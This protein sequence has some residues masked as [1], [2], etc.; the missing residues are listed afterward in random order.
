MSTWGC[1]FRKTTWNVPLL[2]VRFLRYGNSRSSSSC[3]LPTFRSQKRCTPTAMGKVLVT[4]RRS[5]VIGKAIWLDICRLPKGWGRGST[6]DAAALRVGVMRF[7][8][9][10]P[11]SGRTT[12]HTCLVGF[13]GRGLAL[14]YEHAVCVFLM[15]STIM[16]PHQ[17]FMVNP[18]ATPLPRSSLAKFLSCSIVWCSCW[19]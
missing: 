2:Y 19:G 12:D 17:M 5:V 1:A 4:P 10:L 18:C 7:T 13:G 11:N 8:H 16:P 14:S 15:P 9:R 6:W 3:P